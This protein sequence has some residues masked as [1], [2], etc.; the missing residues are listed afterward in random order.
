VLQCLVCGRYTELSSV[1]GLMKYGRL[2]ASSEAL[3]KL[4]PRIDSALQKL[5]PR[6]DSALQK[7]LP[8]IDSSENCP[9]VKHFTE[10]DRETLNTLRFLNT[11][12]LRSQGPRHEIAPEL[13]EQGLALSKCEAYDRP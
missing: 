4:L 1:R 10:E 6:I 9:V 7:L 12:R 2:A 8:G 11:L 3:Q 13:I 5:P